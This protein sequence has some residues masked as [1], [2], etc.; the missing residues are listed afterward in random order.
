MSIEE[1]ALLLLLAFLDGL[2]MKKNMIYY[3]DTK[4]RRYLKVHIV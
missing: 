2:Y 4:A 1:F 3:A